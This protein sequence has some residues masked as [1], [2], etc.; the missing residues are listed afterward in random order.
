MKKWLYAYTAVGVLFGIII[1]YL[2]ESRKAYK[3]YAK[4][5]ENLV[6][7]YRKVAVK[8]VNTFELLDSTDK[9]GAE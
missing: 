4:E 8:A 6:E 5:L 2:G 1:G 9:V 3:N 7:N